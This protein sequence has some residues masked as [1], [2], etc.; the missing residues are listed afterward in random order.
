MKRVDSE[1]DTVK[2]SLEENSE[3]ALSLVDLMKKINK[4][5]QLPIFYSGGLRILEK[6]LNNSKTSSVFSADSCDWLC[7]LK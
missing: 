3:E 2:K 1:E 5:N 7:Q 6:K 4:A